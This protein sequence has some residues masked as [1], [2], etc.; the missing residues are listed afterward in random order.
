MPK[1]S[2]RPD[3]FQSSDDN[4]N[5]APISS[6]VRPTSILI[7][8]LAAV[9]ILMIFAVSWAPD[10]RVT[11]LRWVPGWIAD[12]ADRDPNNRTAI[13][14][15]PLAFLLVRGFKGYKPNGSLAWPLMIS[16]LCLGLSEFGQKFIPHRTADVRDLLWG[17]IGILIGTAMAWISSHWRRS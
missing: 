10:S 14:F 6:R 11:T 2:K 1:V 7:F 12:L 5:A 16:G 15:I 8:A 13:P 9:L 4:M 3:G 17:G